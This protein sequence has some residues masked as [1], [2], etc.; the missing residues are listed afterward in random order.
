[1]SNITMT[2]EFQAAVAQAVAQFLQ[3]QQQQQGQQPIE[4]PQRPRRDLRTGLMPQQRENRDAARV[5]YREQV[6]ELPVD[7]S[8]RV[9]R[10]GGEYTADDLYIPMDRELTAQEILHIDSNGGIKQTW[11]D[12]ARV[13]IDRNGVKVYLTIRVRRGDKV[14]AKVPNTD[15]YLLVTFP[16]LREAVKSLTLPQAF[17]F[18]KGGFVSENGM[19]VGVGMT[20]VVENLA[21][22]GQFGG[23]GDEKLIELPRVRFFVPENIALPVIAT[24]FNTV[25]GQ[26]GDPRQVWEDVTTPDP[27]TGEIAGAHLFEDPKY[28]EADR[29]WLHAHIK[30][31]RR[32]NT[33]WAISDEML[34][35]CRVMQRR[36]ERQRDVELRRAR[37]FGSLIEFREQR[38][39]NQARQAE[40]QAN[41]ANGRQ[42]APVAPRTMALPAPVAAPRSF[43]R[44]AATVLSAP[45]SVDD[46]DLNEL[47]AAIEGNTA[48]VDSAERIQPQRRG[49]GRQSAP[50]SDTPIF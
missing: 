49:R 30:V 3:Q 39:E 29:E 44:P 15:Q 20:F 19:R 24:M 6:A 46:L 27:L 48:T 13:F 9:G 47:D 28:A 10:A 35:T 5:Q 31:A 8:T 32:G 36:D 1:M 40:Y 25:E 23:K 37:L 2:P 43:G 22:R 7:A 45:Q 17:P 18:F 11:L 4:Q 42:Q 26:R 21:L 38:D 41:R 16:N 14:E 12:T 34:R 33:K 50:A